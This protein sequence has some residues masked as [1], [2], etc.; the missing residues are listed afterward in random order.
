MKLVEM[1]WSPTD[2]QL[3]QFAII[4]LFALPAVGWIWSGGTQV[5]SL[6]AAIGLAIAIAGILVPKVVKPIFL[7]LTIVAT[8]IG[9]VISELAL[10]LIYFAVFLPI[11]LLF[12]V[13]KR[14]ALHL[15][16]DRKAVTYWQAKQQP[17]NVTSYYRQS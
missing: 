15:N 4:C 10:L 7:A 6:L 12:R 5:V 2:R 8:P 14:D 16:L 17:T 13:M 3:R 9:M 11:G 1:N